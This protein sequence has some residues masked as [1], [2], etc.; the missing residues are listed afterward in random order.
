MQENSSVL[1]HGPLDKSPLADY[2]TDMPSLYSNLE[3]RSWAE[4]HELNRN[5]LPRPPYSAHFPI[6]MSHAT[7]MVLVDGAL[8]AAVLPIPPG[9]DNVNAEHRAYC[10]NLHC[11]TLTFCLED[12]PFVMD[13]HHAKMERI[14]GSFPQVKATYYAYFTLYTFQYAM[15]EHGRLCIRVSVRNEDIKA[16]RKHVWIKLAHP[17]EKS[18]YD[19]HYV[20]YHFTANNFPKFDTSCGF[21]DNAFWKDGQAVGRVLPG[22]FTAQWHDSLFA[23]DAGYTDNKFYWD[24]PY[25]VHPEYRL[26]S[27]KNMLQLSVDLQPGEERSFEVTMDTT[28]TS[29]LPAELPP[30]DEVSRWNQNRWQEEEQEIATVDFGDAKLNDRFLALQRLSRQLLFDMKW[31]GREPI[32]FPCQGGTSERFFMWVWEAM[33]EF[34]PMLRLGYFQEARA[35]LEFVFS[36][37]DGGYPPVGEFVEAKGAIGTTGPKWACVTG[38]ALTW[39]ALY[40][41]CS[42][43]DDFARKHL[44]AMAK[45]CSWITAQIRAPHPADYP[46]PGLMPKCCSTDADYGRLIITTDNWSCRGMELAAQV[47]T[48]YGHPDA[49]KYTREAA[50]YKMDLLACVQDLT[51][52]DGYVRR[53]IDDS[54]NYCPGFVNCDSYSYLAYS[55]LVSL[56]DPSMRRFIRWCEENSCQDFF[57]GAMTPHLIYIGTGEEIAAL[58]QMANG[59]YKKAWSAIQTF[60]RYGCSQDLFL[61]QERFDIDD[62]EHVSWQPNSSNNGRMLDMELARLYLETDQKIVL[63]GGFAPFELERPGRAFSIHGLHTRYGRLDLEAKD[64]RVSIHWENPPALPVVLPDGWSLN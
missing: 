37:Q 40:L 53:Q 39:A 9:M 30:F 19:Y 17:L 13:F 26:Y 7:D 61:T 32:L 2:L 24:S 14:G 47:L 29:G 45:A 50:R 28:L 34:Q 64:H 15:G 20:T 54:G 52:P 62:P 22:E 33:C 16:G 58:V 11:R 1:P 43:D 36:L 35:L 23:K 31:P 46:Y 42:Q 57:F 6:N 60:E 44:D 51:L 63:L 56:H 27:A 41:E 55:G 4:V 21:H 8:N 10:A 25:F 49:E 48:Q 38:S 5:N 18:F 12:P 3:E 59:E